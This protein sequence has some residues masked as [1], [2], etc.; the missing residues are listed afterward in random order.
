MNI[1]RQSDADSLRDL[2]DA[3]NSQ[4]G[5][6]ILNAIDF[7]LLYLIF[8]CLSRYHRMRNSS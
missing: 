1:R 6:D 2:V 3:G 5:A 8:T 7:H 4:L